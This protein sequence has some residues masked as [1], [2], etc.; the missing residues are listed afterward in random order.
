[1]RLGI[2]KKLALSLSSFLLIVFAFSCWGIVSY[3]TRLL[4]ENIQKQQFA[5][6]ELI[7]RGIDD[8]LGAYLVTIAQV[9]AAV[10]ADAFGNPDKAQAFLD[11][12]RDLRSV[13]DNGI[14]LFDNKPSLV[15]ESP[16]IAGRRGTK[17]ER[18]EQFLRTV[19]ENDFPDISNPYI[20]PKT[21][22]PAIVMADP[23]TDSHNNVRGYLV[24]SINLT[25]DYFIEGLMSYKIGK[26]GYLYLFNTER[27]MIL[28]PDKNRIMRNDIPPGANKLLDRAIEGFEGSGETVNTQGV[29]Q[30]ASFKRLKMVDWI[31]ASAYPQEEAYAPIKRLRNY[32][33]AAASLVTLLSIVLIWLLT[34]RI[35]ASLDSFTGQV[36]L[37]RENPERSH[38]IHVVSSDEVSLL[39]DTFNGLMRELDL[40]RDSLDEMTR[41]DYLTGLFNRRHLEMEAPKL[42]AISERQKA[43]TA[44][45]MVDIDHFKR[46][47]DAH[48][49]ETGDAV[50]VHLAKMLLKTVR[51]YDMV[52]R[53]G[54]EEFLLLLP[55]TTCNGAMGVAERLRCNIQDTPVTHHNETISITAS[56]GVYVV[57]QM[58]DL[59]DAIAR[60]DAALYEAKNSGRNRVCLAPTT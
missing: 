15:A 55:L 17:V 8:K 40:A 58:H 42:I 10:P 30:I 25:K 48:G 38:E 1:M 23:I 12:H 11:A 29:P 27:T 47:N 5:M 7:A 3:T 28:H 19:G 6:T 35:T 51:P 9:A 31:L 37:I 59:Q 16:F 54:G 32:L 52:V 43:S 36:R 24:G 22:A 26:K 2:Q 56:I 50:L 21:N 45:L 4:R 53:L 13:F 33:I 34:S 46:I 44:V 18:L 49:H 39:A 60:A 20:S 57:E 14:I 41:T